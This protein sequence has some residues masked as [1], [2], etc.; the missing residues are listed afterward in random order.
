[1]AKDLTQMILD[2]IERNYTSVIGG[3][4]HDIEYYAELFVATNDIL[5]SKIKDNYKNI[6]VEKVI[7]SL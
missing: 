7:T 1:M 3:V 5:D 4:R 6:F 2:D